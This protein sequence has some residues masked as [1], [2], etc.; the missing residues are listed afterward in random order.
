MANRSYRIQD[1]TFNEFL[2][3]VIMSATTKQKSRLPYDLIRWTYAPGEAKNFCEKAPLEQRLEMLARLGIQWKVWLAPPDG[4]KKS[5]LTETLE[6]Y[7]DEQRLQSIN[8][9]ISEKQFV[10]GDRDVM[11]VLSMMAQNCHSETYRINREYSKLAATIVDASTKGP[12]EAHVF[13]KVLEDY[14]L[15]LKFVLNILQSQD[16]VDGL[17]AFERDEIMVLVFLF[18]HRNAYIDIKTISKQ[19]NAHFTAGKIRSTI[20]GLIRAG[21]V[22]K[23]PGKSRY[24]ITSAGVQTIANFLGRAIYQ[25]LV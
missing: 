22:D 5:T 2:F 12:S 8:G 13:K 23:F 11:T 19:F 1:P 3:H 9:M 18:G 16:F 20:G 10:F 14:R 24:T 6:Q 15:L 25:T 7:K 17:S 21:H 4:M